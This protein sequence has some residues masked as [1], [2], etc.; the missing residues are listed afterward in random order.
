MGR[1]LF[2]A[3]AGSGKNAVIDTTSYYADNYISSISGN[4]HMEYWELSFTK[5]KSASESYIWVKG[6][7]CGEG[8]VNY[9]YIGMYCTIDDYGRNTNDDRII[10]K[11]KQL[12]GLGFLNIFIYPGGL[13]EWLC[14]QDIYGFEQF[15]TTK[16]ELDILKFK[17]TPKIS[18]LNLLTNA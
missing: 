16:R 12:M 8:H 4:N 3:A 15:P 5:Q 14:L 13:F 17:A 1:S 6:L 11:Y 7:L 2:N 10:N 18:N 9:P